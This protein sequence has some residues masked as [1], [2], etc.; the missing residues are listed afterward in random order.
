MYLSLDLDIAN[1]IMICTENEVKV[2]L[3]DPVLESSLT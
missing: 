1:V 2:F 3:L